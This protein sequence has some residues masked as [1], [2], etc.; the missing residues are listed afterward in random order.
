MLL[1]FRSN[2]AVRQVH[3]YNCNQI[4]AHI[5]F[6]SI[7][8]VCECVIGAVARLLVLIHKVVLMHAKNIVRE[9]KLIVF[10]LMHAVSESHNK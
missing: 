5:Q 6:L 2:E 8:C 4:V 7:A 10:R 1:V 3:L 9:I